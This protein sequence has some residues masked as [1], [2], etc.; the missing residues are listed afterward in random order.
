MAENEN[1]S[2]GVYICGDC[3]QS[4][5][6]DDLLETHASSEHLISS[7]SCHMCGHATLTAKDL[8]AHLMT[9]PEQQYFLELQGPNSIE[10]IL[11]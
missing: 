5:A 6:T 2:N 11:A 8:E 3:G 4:F 10:N 7:H 1:E 9:H